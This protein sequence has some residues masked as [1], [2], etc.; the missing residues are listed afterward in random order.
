[1]RCPRCGA[2]LVMAVDPDDVDLREAE[3]EARRERWRDLE[4]EALLEEAH[5]H[6]EER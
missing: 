4:D 6:E 5:R 1:M 2:H 3:A